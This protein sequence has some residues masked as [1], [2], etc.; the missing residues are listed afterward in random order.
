M[1][2]RFIRDDTPALL[3]YDTDEFN[4]DNVL[5]P[6]HLD[7]YFTDEEFGNACLKGSWRNLLAGTHRR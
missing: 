3:E 6:Y 1:D 7:R 4:E 5:S 2:I